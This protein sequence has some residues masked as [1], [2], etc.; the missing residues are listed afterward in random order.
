MSDD[1]DVP[2]VTFLIVEDNPP[3]DEDC[4]PVANFDIPSKKSFGFAAGDC[5]ENFDLTVDDSGTLA[6]P[7]FTLGRGG[8]ILTRNNVGDIT[9]VKFFFRPKGGPPSDEVPTNNHMITPVTP[10]ASG[11]QVVVNDT[12]QIL[13]SQSKKASEIGIIEVGTVIFTPVP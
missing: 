4:P 2:N 3:I 8:M 1:P 9:S 13:E 11:F 6:D 5:L 12:L 7:L 10:N